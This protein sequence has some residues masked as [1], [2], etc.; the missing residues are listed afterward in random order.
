MAELCLDTGRLL[1]DLL[2]SCYIQKL[3]QQSGGLL[4]ESRKGEAEGEALLPRDED[5]LQRHGCCIGRFACWMVERR[6]TRRRFTNG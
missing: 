4:L 1:I 5:S 3:R 6:R 2:L